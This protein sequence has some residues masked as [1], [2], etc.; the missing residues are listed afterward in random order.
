MSLR[1]ALLCWQISAETPAGSAPISYQSVR[2]RCYRPQG[3]GNVFAGVS[4]STINLVATRS[5]LGLTARS[6]RILLECFFVC[7]R[8]KRS[9]GQG[10]IFTPVC[11]SVHRGGCFSLPDPPTGADPPRMENPP[12]WRNPPGMENPPGADTTPGW[13]TPPW[14]GEP[15]PEQ[16]PP[17]MENP[18]PGKQTPAYGLRSAGTHPTGMHSCFFL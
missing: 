3:E 2:V 10:N 16:T 1:S 4:L 12:G 5:L 7:Y 13:R 15:P 9:F 17:R 14:H 11:H 18:P 8:P 6:V